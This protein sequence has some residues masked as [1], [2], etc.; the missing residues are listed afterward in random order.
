MWGAF[1]NFV[2]R[3]FVLFCGRDFGKKICPKIFLR[4]MVLKQ[5]WYQIYFL[6]TFQKTVIDYN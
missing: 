1:G 6:F 2:F 5:L 3:E 4:P